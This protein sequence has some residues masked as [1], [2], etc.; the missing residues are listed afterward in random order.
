MNSRHLLMAT[1]LVCT[2]AFAAGAQAHDMHDASKHMQETNA[3]MQS[4]PAD[5]QNMAEE[6]M[7]KSFDRDRPLFQEMH[8]L[9]DRMMELGTADKFDSK[10]FLKASDQMAA[11]HMKM[12][13]HHAEMM[14]AVGEQLTGEERRTIAHCMEEQFHHAGPGEHGDMHHEAAPADANSHNDYSN[15]NH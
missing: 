9:H 11:L 10:A 5:K 1:A 7:H 15:L 8:K 14:A 13:R 2:M 3:C 4:L 12:E 6:T